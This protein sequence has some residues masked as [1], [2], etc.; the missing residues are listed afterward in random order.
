MAVTKKSARV[1][2]KEEKVGNAL[3]LIGLVG[4]PLL[5]GLAFIQSRRSK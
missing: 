4:F 2:T 1:K 3:A 5:I